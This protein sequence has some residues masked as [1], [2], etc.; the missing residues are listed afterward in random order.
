MKIEAEKDVQLAEIAPEEQIVNSTYVVRLD[1][2]LTG[3]AA[4]I[5]IPLPYEATNSYPDRFSQDTAVIPNRVPECQGEKRRELREVLAHLA[6]LL[7]S[8]YI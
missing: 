3:K 8:K 2:L 7:K 6:R 1:Y 4:N 5:Y